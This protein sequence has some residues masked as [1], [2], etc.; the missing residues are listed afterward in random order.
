M[1]RRP[2]PLLLTALLL[3]GCG[4]G[5]PFTLRVVFPDEAARQATEWLRLV[6]IAPGQ[7]ADC[8]ELLSG[9]AS[10]GEPGYAIEA[11]VTL[12]YPLAGSPA[13]LDLEAAGDKLFFA[14]AQDGSLAVRLRGCSAV[15]VGEGAPREASVSLQ[16]LGEHCQADADCPDDLLWC[17]GTPRCVDWRCQEEPPACDDGVGCTQDACDEDADAC[18]H[19]PRDGDCD[20]GDVCTGQETCDPRAGCVDGQPLECDDGEFCDG[21]EGCDPALGCQAGSPPSCDDGVPCTLDACDAGTDACAHTPNAG[22][23]PELHV[24]PEP[25]S[26]PHELPD[27]TPVTTCDHAGA[28]GL[29]A[30]SQAAPAEGARFLLHGQADLPGRFTGPVHVPGG[31][32]VGAAPGV[33]PAH[34]VLAAPRDA[35]NGALQLAGDGVHVDGL[36]ILVVYDNDYAISAWPAAATPAGATR[37]HL[38]ERVTAFAVDPEV[39]GTNGIGPP[40]ALGDACTV[41]N[42]HFYGYFELELQVQGRADVRL[43]HNTFVLFQANDASPIDASG[44]RGF[45][46]A[47]NVVL[48]LAQEEPVLVWADLAAVDLVLSGNLVEGFA[49]VATGHNPGDPGTRVVDNLL[50]PAE[51]ESPRS[52]RFLADSA[53][54]VAGPVAGEGTSLDGVELAG[55]AGARPG[56]FQRPS[57][58]GLPRRQV[59]RLGRGDCGGEGCD[60]DADAIGQDVQE[61][62]W[63]AW[64]GAEVQVFPSAS[65]YAGFALLGWP[66]RLRGMGA[67]VDEVVLE[68]AYDDALLEGLDVY[69]R[70]DATLI[71]LEKIADPVLVSDLTVRLDAAR[72]GDNWGVYTEDRAEQADWPPHRLERLRL[73]SSGTELGLYAGFYLG[74]RTVV[75]DSLVWGGFRACVRLGPRNS[76]SNASTPSNAKLV[77]LTCRLI[78]VGNQVP[79]AFLDVAAADGA[80]FVD[81]AAESIAPVPLLRAQRRASGDTG[82]AAL[83]P[84]LSYQ[85]V[86]VSAKNASALH[87]GFDAASGSYTETG[88]ELLGAADA[89][90]VDEGDSHLAPGSTALDTGVDPGTLDALLAPGTSLDGVDRATVLALDRG[91]YEQGQ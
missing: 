31:S 37:G 51:L 78:G 28:G 38:I 75:Q 60:L 42:C 6:A 56:A 68:N 45:T 27:G 24:G 66:V 90:F 13:G 74:T 41:R 14:E 81:L 69:N 70:H 2:S 11:E 57:A 29:I 30:A 5:E 89:L 16:W 79:Q 52:P 36:T 21:A 84:P 65:P 76:E 64:P 67:A 4:G 77:N 80:V 3:A 15:V 19:L 43:V 33:D 54:R 91:C 55:L 34:V 18:S 59:V 32:F 62:V 20:D 88:V 82:A 71:L 26:C 49:G 35:D 63:S 23:C 83:D 22:G 73:A 47:N 85:A 44:S 12:G 25:D 87:D 10:P 61:A 1:A 72:S 9:L 8:V 58:L 48:S 86:S 50:A 39:R 53:Q 17:T 46:F 40:V 7:G